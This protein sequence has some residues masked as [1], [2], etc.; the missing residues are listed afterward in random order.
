[1]AIQLSSY[2]ERDVRPQQRQAFKKD[3]KE[4]Q[5]ILLRVLASTHYRHQTLY[6]RGFVAKGM[7]NA[8]EKVLS[9]LRCEVPLAISYELDQDPIL[10]RQGAGLISR[11]EKGCRLPKRLEFVGTLVYDSPQAAGT[12]SEVFRI[13]YKRKQLAAK[14]LYSYHRETG[15]FVLEEVGLRPSEGRLTNMR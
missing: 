3:H 4:I 11:L 13:E 2:L 9:P 15:P 6:L 12:F 14:R 7:L 8:L 5:K 1:M 10:R